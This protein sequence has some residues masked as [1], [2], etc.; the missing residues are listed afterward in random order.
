MELALRR[1]L[2]GYRRGPTVTLF[3]TLEQDAVSAQRAF[4]QEM[5]DLSRR[6]DE[7]MAELRETEALIAAEQERQQVVLALLDELARRGAAAVEAA[8]SSMAAEEAAILGR[9]A[10]REMRLARRRQVLYGLRDDVEAAVRQA[11]GELEP[12][13]GQ[14]AA[15]ETGMAPDAAAGPEPEADFLTTKRAG[16]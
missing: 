9:I 5:Q 2:I 16:A 6:L 1:A 12:Q 13:A 4:D 10:Q 8:K 3:Q 14:E 7:A 11:L 15:H